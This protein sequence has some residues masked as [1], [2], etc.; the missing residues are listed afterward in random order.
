MM[1]K[2]SLIDTQKIDKGITVVSIDRMIYRSLSAPLSVQ[3][4][5]PLVPLSSLSLVNWIYR[6][7]HHRG[8][9]PFLPS[10]SFLPSDCVNEW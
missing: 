1:S 6:M 4:P 8:S 5:Q 2:L 7:T 3:E 10:S 9:S